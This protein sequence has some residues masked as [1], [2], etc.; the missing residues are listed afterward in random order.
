ML[1]L[2]RG[3]ALLIA[4]LAGASAALAEQRPAVVVTS[5][6]DQSFR[7]AL[8]QFSGGPGAEQYRIGLRDAL[9]YSNLFRE[10]DPRAF[11]GPTTTSSFGART[12]FDCS[13]W[14]TIGADAFVE[15]VLRIDGS[16]FVAEFGVWDLA[17]CTRKIRRRYRQA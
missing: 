16:D 3:T 6:S 2:S 14:I 11:L 1:R 8:Q 10:I 7:I 4:L 17:G 12:R 15:G 13:E 9:E 5:G